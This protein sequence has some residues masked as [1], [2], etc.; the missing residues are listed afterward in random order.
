MKFLEFKVWPQILLNCFLVIVLLTFKNEKSRSACLGLYKVSLMPCRNEQI[1]FNIYGIVI[2][3]PDLVTVLSKNYLK[4][5]N[6][7][8][9]FH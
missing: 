8:P 3:E 9:G 4:V 5:C 7:K 1:S 2:T 6:L